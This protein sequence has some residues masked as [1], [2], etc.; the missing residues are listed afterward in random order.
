MCVFVGVVG[1]VVVVAVVVVV[2][3]VADYWREWHMSTTPTIDYAVPETKHRA[4]SPAARVCADPC[5][6]VTQ[7]LPYPVPNAASF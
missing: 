5:G 2:V 3:C 7:S 1:V 6:T 4:Q